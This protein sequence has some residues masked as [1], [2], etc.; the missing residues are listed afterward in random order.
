[1]KKYTLLL[2]LIALLSLIAC[3]DANNLEDYSDKEG[4]YPYELSESEKNILRSF[5][6]SNNSHIVS[7]NAP[8]EAIT[9]YV[10]VY[11]LDSSNSW[12]LIGGSGTSIGKER[13]PVDRLTGSFSMI[14]KD[15]KVIDCFIDCGGVSNFQ[16]DEIILKDEILASKICFL[17]EFRD[18]ELNKEIP[19]ALMIYSSNNYMYTYSLEDF[20]EPE[21][22]GD[23]DLVQ[24]ITM[25]FTDDE[26]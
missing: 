15:N 24:V 22:L 12:N 10:N 21:R 14:L 19:I 26:L 17:N 3:N 25:S 23:L 11:S 13:I 7:F 9:F 2:L 18:I 16:V 20:Y 6:M 4:I 5:G 1:M 8:I